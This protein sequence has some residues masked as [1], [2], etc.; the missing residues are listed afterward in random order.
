MRKDTYTNFPYGKNLASTYS[1]DFDLK[2]IKRSPDIYLRSKHSGFDGLYKEHLPTGLISTMKFD[3]KPF[4][5]KM[6]DKQQE[7]FKIMSV[8]FFGRTTNQANYA[9]WGDIS[10][11]NREK[12]ELPEIKVPCRGNSNYLENYI[13]HDPDRYINRV[14]MNFSKGTLKFYGKLNP[15]TTFNTSFKPVDLNQPHYFNRK[16]I[17]KT[18]VEGKSSLEPAK[19]PNS[20]IESLYAESYIDFKDKMCQLA[21]HLRKTGIKCLEI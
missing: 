6:E 3:F 4:K 5:V 10:V 18:M 7:D 2:D 1:G 13:N 17:T 16:R 12:V 19:F 14:P 20:N 11:G 8:P 9:N 15:E 21:E